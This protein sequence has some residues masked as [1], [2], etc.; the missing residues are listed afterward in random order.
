M[1]EEVIKYLEQNHV[2]FLELTRL[3]EELVTKNIEM[4]DRIGV[5]ESK[6]WDLELKLAE[7]DMR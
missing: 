3:F 7:D 1:N 6:V 5:L 2:N 4:E